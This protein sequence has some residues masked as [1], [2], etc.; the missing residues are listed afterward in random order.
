[1]SRKLG[2]VQTDKDAAYQVSLDDIEWADEIFA[3][4]KRHKNLL[5]KRFNSHLK[6]KKIIT[7]NIPD[8]YKYMDP[9]LIEILKEKL[10][11]FIN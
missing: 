8:E 2:E 10:K 5:T 11:D 9:F 7:L 3:M 1:M 4:E 6:N